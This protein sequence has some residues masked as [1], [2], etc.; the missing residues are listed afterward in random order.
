VSLLRNRVRLDPFPSSGYQLRATTDYASQ[1]VGSE[2]RYMRVYGDGT[3]YRELREGVV[4]SARLAAGSFVRSA[5]S[6]GG[7]IPP[8]RRF[9]GGG[10]TSV[11]GFPRNELGP[12]VYIRRIR[13][14]AEGP[15][16]ARVITADSTISSSATGGTRS[17]LGTA[18]ITAVSPILS[19]VLRLAVFVDAGQ[20]WDPA[21]Q[22]EV[23]N[24]GVRVTPGVG[25]RYATPVGPLR[26]DV[27][28]NP[29]DPAPG[30][31][32]DVDALDRLI[33][34]PVDPRYQPESRG[35]AFALSRFIF[36]ISV[37]QTF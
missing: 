32:F 25:I 10:P 20:V 31:L 28:Y 16:T 26:L 8:N 13:L 3:I 23:E 27:G 9:Y 37:G 22:V 6:D 17:V 18:E 2:D 29:Y 34:V 1:L 5:V 19:N 33:P 14:S 30:P 12:Q 11:R 4:L 15:D 21:A 36:Q 35:G 7:Y 24:P